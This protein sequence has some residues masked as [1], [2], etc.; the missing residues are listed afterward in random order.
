M[1]RGASDSNDFINLLILDN[2]GNSW[3]AVAR[4]R[5]QRLRGTSFRVADGLAFLDVV[6]E[7]RIGPQPV[8]ESL[9]LVP[10]QLSPSIPG[11]AFR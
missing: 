9:T 6:L 2:F 3:H 1:A 8:R 10:R 4:A 11:L 7:G 5:G